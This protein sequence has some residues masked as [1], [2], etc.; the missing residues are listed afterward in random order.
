MENEALEGLYTMHFNTTKLEHKEVTNYRFINQGIENSSILMNWAD[1]F[2]F[3]IFVVIIYVIA[4][5]LSKFYKPKKVDTKTP[6]R[7]IYQV[8]TRQK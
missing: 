1:L 5:I 4:L 6:K 2:M 7:N 3:I 8:D